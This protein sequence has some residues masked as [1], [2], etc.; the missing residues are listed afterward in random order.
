MTTNT[1]G[2]KKTKQ[3]GSIDP[4]NPRIYKGV[5]YR[6]RNEACAARRR[7][8]VALLKTGQY[9]YTE[10]A[11]L[12]G[13]SKRTGKTWRNG[14]KHT[15]RA[16][17]PPCTEWVL[18]D[19]CP[20]PYRYRD[21]RGRQVLECFENDAAVLFDRGADEPFICAYGYD[22]AT[23]TAERYQ[24][25]EHGIS[26]FI[27]ADHEVITPWCVVWTRTDVAGVIEAIGAEPSEARI[28]A[29][30]DLMTLRY[31]NGTFTSNDCDQVWAALDMCANDFVTA[32]AIG[33]D[34]ITAEAIYIR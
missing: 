21:A 33:Y 15:D 1:T 8:Y 17:E 31:R 14:R 28:D 5:E 25:Y 18:R 26:A 29:V 27:R 16:D 12:V 9:N 30:I 2:A 10:A 23:G 34:I 20:C 7:D 13:V 32:E 4:K 11:A 6:T 19:A 22:Q 24:T 3:T